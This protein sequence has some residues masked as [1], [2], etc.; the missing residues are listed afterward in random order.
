MDLYSKIR[1]ADAR[2]PRRRRTGE[3]EEERPRSIPQRGR[4]SFS[5]DSRPAAAPPME[6]REHRGPPGQQ[7]QRSPFQ[8]RREDSRDEPRVYRTARS[9]RE[10]PQTRTPFVRPRH[11]DRPDSP[12]AVNYRR[13]AE[14]EIIEPR[15]AWR[16]PKFGDIMVDF[17][18]R[19]F[20]V[21]LAAGFQEAAW[22][23]GERRRFHAP[24]YR[25]EWD[26]GDR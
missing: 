1:S 21:S 26:Y 9:T 8:T 14:P 22:F 23:W 10:E 2:E 24:G 13:S 19:V 4:F 6:R 25:R 18:L 7:G 15:E 16:P 12:P 20:E 3:E 11:Y 5:G 17:L